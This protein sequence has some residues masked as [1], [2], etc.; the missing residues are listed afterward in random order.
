MN[1]LSLKISPLG[2]GTTDHV[3]PLGNWFFI[4][5]SR[6][7]HWISKKFLWTIR[8]P[9]SLPSNLITPQVIILGLWSDPIR[10]LFSS[11]L[12]GPFTDLIWCSCDLIGPYGSFIEYQSD[13]FGPQNDFW[14]P[15]WTHLAP[16]ISYWAP[17][18]THWAPQWPHWAPQWPLG[19]SVTSLGSLSKPLLTSSVPFGTLLDSQVI[20]LTGFWKRKQ[21]QLVL[22]ADSK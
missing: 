11:D 1:S 4:G 13:L 10:H 22:S 6:D 16:H 9:H 19:L 17:Q 15:Q 5:P 21:K 18:W 3:L 12:T 2:K 14:E 7:L 20:S 8:W